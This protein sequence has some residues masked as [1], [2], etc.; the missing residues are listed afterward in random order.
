[1]CWPQSKIHAGKHPAS[2]S[3]AMQANK[4]LTRQ[5]CGSQVFSG[6]YKKVDS[7]LLQVDNHMLTYPPS[8]AGRVWNGSVSSDPE[9]WA[10]CK[11]S[12]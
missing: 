6:V 12:L 11:H 8:S 10:H 7:V 5:D 9:D 4:K 1:M 3:K 2:K